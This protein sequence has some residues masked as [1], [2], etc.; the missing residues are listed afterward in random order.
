MGQRL[1]LP[2][3]HRAAISAKLQQYLLLAPFSY[4]QRVTMGRQKDS[5]GFSD[6][7]LVVITA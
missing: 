5:H 7:W 6:G 3:Q 4:Q 1:S 2:A